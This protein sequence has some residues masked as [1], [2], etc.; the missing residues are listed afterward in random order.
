[1]EDRNPLLEDEDAVTLQEPNK[2]FYWY[3]SITC[4]V[5]FTFLPSFYLMGRFTL[6]ILDISISEF[7]VSMIFCILLGCIISIVPICLYMIILK[8]TIFYEI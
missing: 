6:L 7:P 2:P 3:A 5:V 8:I 1:M 4:F